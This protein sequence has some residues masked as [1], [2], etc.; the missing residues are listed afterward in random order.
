[1]T[2]RFGESETAC[3][4]V[5]IGKL[6]RDQSPRPVIVATA[7]GTHSTQGETFARDPLSRSGRHGAAGCAMSGA[8]L[9][10]SVAPCE[11]VGVKDDDRRFTQARY[12]SAT[13]GDFVAFPRVARSPDDGRH[14]RVGPSPR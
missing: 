10:A 2:V 9:F 11:T 3:G 13:F 12:V 14:S 8:S 4:E 6:G 7:P 1:M 5:T